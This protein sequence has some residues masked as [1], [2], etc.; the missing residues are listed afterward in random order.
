MDD[1][2]NLKKISEKISFLGIE[3]YLIS[4]CDFFFDDEHFYA[5]NENNEIVK[6]KIEEIAELKRTG[7]IVSNRP[8]WSIKIKQKNNDEIFHYQ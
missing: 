7:T 4:D 5:I 1:E 6:Y 2:K 3:N 8:I